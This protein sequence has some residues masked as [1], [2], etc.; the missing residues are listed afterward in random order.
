MFFYFIFCPF[1]LFYKVC[2]YY[3]AKTKCLYYAWLYGIS[4]K[5]RFDLEIICS[6][7]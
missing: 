1:L 7:Y 5:V 3:F 2:A 4:Y 6:L